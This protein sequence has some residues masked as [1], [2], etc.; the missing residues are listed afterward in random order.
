MATD[1]FPYPHFKD[2]KLYDK[3]GGAI[4][5]SSKPNTD[6]LAWD[7]SSNKFINESRTAIGLFR[8]NNKMG[9][10]ESAYVVPAQKHVDNFQ[11]NCEAG[12]RRVRTARVWNNNIA[13]RIDRLLK[14]P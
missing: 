2:D 8:H 10:L 14:C 11:L 6:E 12:E 13:G 9:I 5:N 4:P 3:L 1:P 7:I